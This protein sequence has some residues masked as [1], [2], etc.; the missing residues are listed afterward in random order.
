MMAINKKHSTLIYRWTHIGFISQIRF[1]FHEHMKSFSPFFLM[2]RSSLAIITFQTINCNSSFNIC[3]LV[4][5][6]YVYWYN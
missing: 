2:P 3:S 6:D 5:N 1:L 4:Q